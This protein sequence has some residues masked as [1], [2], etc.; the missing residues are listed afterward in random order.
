VGRTGPQASCEQSGYLE[1]W[2]DAWVRIATVDVIPVMNATIEPDQASVSPRTTDR[3]PTA[4]DSGTPTPLGRRLGRATTVMVGL[5]LLGSI[6]NYGSN[7]IFSR[8]LSPA[9]YGDLTALLAFSV[10]AAV[11]TGAAQT[12][13]AERIAVLLA[14]GEHD[15]ARYL[16]RHAFA[17]VGMIALTL[18]FLYA[19]SIPLLKQALSLQAIGPAIALAPLLILSFFIPVAYGVLQGMERFIALGAVMLAVAL[20]RVLIGVPW[21]LAGGGAG[22]PL[23]GQA[24]G[25]LLAMC[26]TAYLLRKYLLRHGTGAARAGLRRRPDQRTLAAGSVFI[27]F[28]LI[29]NLDVLLAKLMLSAHAAGEYAALATVEKIVIFLPGA[30]AVVMVPSAAK[31]RHLDGSAARVL[32]VAALLVAVTA[33][34]AAVPAAVAPHLLLKLM[35]GARYVSAAAGVLPI[36]CAGAGLALLYLLVVYTVAIQDRRWVWLL[37]AGVSL[38]VVSISALHSSPTQ[39]ATVQ[40]CV[41]AL[42][43]IANECGF[44]PILRRARIPRPDAPQRG[45]D[46]WVAP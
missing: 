40:A 21:T 11:P 36:V 4:I 16:I 9:S 12:I 32:R 30:V 42:V 31:A 43:L 13:V 1:P 37:A 28:A 2:P 7:I 45:I 5:T 15:Q 24:L 35:F 39:V 10:I 3:E 23:F 20:S 26:A 44:H 8:L 46:G 18:G 25:C 22:G 17:H 19:M 38:Q 29:S 41:V 27:G 34:L 14:R 33:L 6:T